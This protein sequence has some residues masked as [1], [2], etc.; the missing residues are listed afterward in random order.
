MSNIQT[1]QKV[2]R[3]TQ[4]FI[5]IKC[6]TANEADKAPLDIPALWERFYSENIMDKIPGKTSSE[7]YAL[8]YE[9]EKDHTKPYSVPHLGCLVDSLESIPEGL[10]GHEIP[11]STYEIFPAV[12]KHP[13]TLIHTWQ[14]IWSA[15]LDRTFS[16]DFE[17]YR[18]D[19]FK[20]SP[21][22]VNIYIAVKK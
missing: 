9:Y 20:T 7:V 5:G 8:Y 3:P 13:E 4:Q 22:E 12:G 19:F 17:L 11:A 1:N 15:D 18:E 14:K 2:T 10:V 21:Q 6:R 16:G